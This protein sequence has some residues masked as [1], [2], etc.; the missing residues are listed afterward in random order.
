MT[1]SALRSRAHQQLLLVNE[2]NHRVKNILTTVQALSVRTLKSAPD[3][4]V[5]TTPVML[6][7]KAR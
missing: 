6:G 5:L 1:T 2:L 7:A 3:K 4:L